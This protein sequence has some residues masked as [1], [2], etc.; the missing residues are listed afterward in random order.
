MN[1]QKVWINIT[2]ITL[3][4]LVFAA[5]YH[6]RMTGFVPISS[7]YLGNYKVYLITTDKEYQFWHILNQGAED[8]AEILGVQY[9]WDAP[10]T[11]D[12]NEQIKLIEKAVDQGAY[13]IMVAADDPKKLSNV[14]EDAKAKSV[15]IIY[16]DSPAYEEASV[17]LATDNYKAGVLAGESMLAELEKA[18][19]ESGSIGIVSMAQKDNTQLREQ[20]FRDAMNQNKNF[21]ILDAAFTNG[22]PD[23]AQQ[24]ARKLMKEHEDLVGLFGTNEGTSRG[25][26]SAIQDANN[27][28]IGIGFDKTDEMMKLLDNGSLKA[29]VVQNPY[30]MGYL[31]MAE[32]AAAIRGEDTGPDFID[33][34]AYVLTSDQ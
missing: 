28:Y 7:S 27:Q 29:I 11:R 1:R 18:G 24:K 15:D 6:Y 30:T 12:V 3:A 4:F 22:E 32:A 21:T 13:A 2:V 9:I 5:W 25:V 19:F 8:M 34:G 20:G 23:V 14:I 17:T 26:G 16:V 33:T 31:G 10:L